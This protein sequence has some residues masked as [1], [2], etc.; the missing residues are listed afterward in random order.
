MDKN[1]DE[2]KKVTELHTAF[3]KTAAVVL[4]LALKGKKD[5][6]KEAL[7]FNGIFGEVSSRLAVALGKWKKNL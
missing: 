5:D 4:D 7:N 3:H 6:A 1:S 2:Y